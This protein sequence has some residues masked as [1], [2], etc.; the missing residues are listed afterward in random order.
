MSNES[1]DILSGANPMK[2]DDELAF[3]QIVVTISATVVIY[4]VLQHIR[5]PQVVC[6]AICGVVL[7][8]S[9]GGHIPGYM[10]TMF[11]KDSLVCLKPL[12]HLIGIL[13][14]FIVGVNLNPKI[15]SDNI[16]FIIPIFICG[17][18]LPFTLGLGIAY[19]M[20]DTMNNYNVVNADGFSYHVPFLNFVLVVCPSMTI[21]AFPTLWRV[22]SDLGLTDV[23]MGTKAITAAFGD[24]IVG[25]IL[26]PLVTSKT[27]IKEFFLTLIFGVIWILIVKFII[28]P[29]L[30]K[31]VIRENSNN[32]NPSLS[33]VAITI[34]IVL[35]SALITNYIGIHYFLG[36]FIIGMVF[37]QE[38]FAENIKYFILSGLNTN[39][40]SLGGI[41]CGLAIL[42]SIVAIVGKTL[43]CIIGAKV[44]GIPFNDASIIGSLMNY[45]G[46]LELI[47][48][49][50]G[51]E[52]NII[53]G[54]VFTIL[55]I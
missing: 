21:T 8:V 17:T 55:Y 33:I 48:L 18:I 36:G 39:I 52:K 26:I 49:N 12:T 6:G 54:N 16:K 13:N 34:S 14:S 3:V 35:L 32:A 24:H 40:S 23:D 27:N 5:Q 38:T 19:I 9:V 15:L 29:L 20:Y 31:F 11:P 50:I 30:Q 10:D 41:E 51:F 28:Y 43:G 2:V 4:A 47:I 22:L 42:S 37:S 7:G 53:N 44:I 45:K 46:A 25:Y 1:N